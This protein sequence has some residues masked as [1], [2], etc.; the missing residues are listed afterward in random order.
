VAK[1]PDDVPAGMI[2]AE[3]VEAMV[4][5]K[6]E[7]MLARLAPDAKPG[8]D[9]G[10]FVQALVGQL[11]SLT[12]QGIG[13][14]KKVEPHVLLAREAAHERMI[15][16]LVAAKAKD[17]EPI[18]KLRAKVLIDEVLVEP[19]WTGPDHK[20]R[21][22]IIGFWG[23]PNQAMVPENDTAREIYAAFTEYL[24]DKVGKPDKPLWMSAGGRVIEGTGPHR[25]Q[26]DG[27]AEVG[28]GHAP[29]RG[30]GFRLVGREQPGTIVETRVLGKT[31]APARQMA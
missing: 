8:G 14:T 9:M 20:A 28:D 2:R 4:S 19:V 16:L 15:G 31:H 30:E 22:T 6:F 12:D 1:Q 27:V 3:D 17:V 18:Y 10:A 24:G 11:A 21:P 25:R 29:A 26:V 23:V 5:L 7:E 13:T